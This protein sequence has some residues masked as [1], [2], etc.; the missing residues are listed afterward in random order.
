VR[1]LEHH[2]PHTGRGDLP[3]CLLEVLT[4]Y[5]HSVKDLFRYLLLIK[6]NLGKVPAQSTDYSFSGKGSEVSTAAGESCLAPSSWSSEAF[7]KSW[8][9]ERAGAIE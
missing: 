7:S 1:D 5:D 8:A 4:G 6:I 2:F 9:T 3:E